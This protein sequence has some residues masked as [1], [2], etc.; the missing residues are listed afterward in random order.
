MEENF[1]ERIANK[2]E[3]QVQAY[4]SLRD[5]RFYQIEKLN[6][7][8][9]LLERQE[10]CM[11]CKYCKIELEKIV[12]D[13]DRLINH[14]GVN[15]SEYEKAVEKILKHLKEKHQVY[16]E[17]HFTY[18]YSAIFALGGLVFGLLTSYGY[19]YSFHPATF[20]LCTGVGTIIGNILGAKKD[21]KCKKEGR[22]L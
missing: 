1:V 6:R 18:N 13:L 12:D 17:H 10:N 19:F 3:E 4:I 15:R 9:K 5:Y 21:K 16:Q 7:I 11:D 20:F 14:S 22:Q 2:V 8:A